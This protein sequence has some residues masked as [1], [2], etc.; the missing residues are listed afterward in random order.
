MSVRWSTSSPLR[1]FGR[2]VMRR[3]EHHAD[4]GVDQVLSWR[5]RIGFELS[6]VRDVSLARPKSSTLTMPSRRSMMLSGLMSR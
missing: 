2:H 5:E 1:L 6:G 4:A 3:A